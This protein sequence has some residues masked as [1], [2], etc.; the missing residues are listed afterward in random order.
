MQTNPDMNPLKVYVDEKDL[1]KSEGSVELP[2]DFVSLSREIASD[3]VHQAL[4]G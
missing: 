1:V 3:S 2:S 4:C